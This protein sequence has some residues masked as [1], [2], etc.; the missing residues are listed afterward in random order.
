M[1]TGHVFIATSL[2]GY[3]ARPDGGLDWLFAS[4]PEGENP[5]YDTFIARM[6]GV[7]M[8]RDSFEAALTLGPW[9]TPGRSW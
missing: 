2:D 7:V 9:F 4:D 5:G 6:D 3:I 8:G 1:V